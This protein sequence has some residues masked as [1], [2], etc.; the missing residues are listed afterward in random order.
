MNVETKVVEAYSYS[1]YNGTKEEYLNFG[2]VHTEDTQVHQ[3]RGYKPAYVLVRDKDMPHYSE[4]CKLETEY[5]HLKSSKKHYS[6]ME[7][8]NVLLA[9]AL[10]LIPG[11]LY[12]TF[13]L[14]QKKRIKQ[15]N[16]EM[17]KQMRAVVAKA[18]PLL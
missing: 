17:E 4:L 6:S 7:W 10:F 5:F 16:E 3:G 13:K 14:R 8:D 12:V 15:H 9:F 18:K 2:W 11:I 1:S